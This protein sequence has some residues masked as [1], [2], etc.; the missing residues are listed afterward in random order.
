MKDNNKHI[1]TQDKSKPIEDWLINILQTYKQ[2]LYKIEYR[3]PKTYWYTVQDKHNWD[4]T[5]NEYRIVQARRYVIKIDREGIPEIVRTNDTDI[6][7]LFGLQS[8]GGTF[9]LMEEVQY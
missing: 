7:D 5:S 8:D 6:S 9:I 1:I 2:K 3:S 4:F